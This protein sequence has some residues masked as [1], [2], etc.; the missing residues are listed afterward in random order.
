MSNTTIIQ[1][2]RE[3]SGRLQSFSVRQHVHF[4]VKNLLDFWT[5]YFIPLKAVRVPV[6]AFSDGAPGTA[7]FDVR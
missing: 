7:A 6:V 1:N 4:S 5:S 2:D 3:P